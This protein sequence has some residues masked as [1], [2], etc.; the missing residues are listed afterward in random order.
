MDNLFSNGD[1]IIAL[2][3]NTLTVERNETVQRSFDWGEESFES[4]VV[5]RA[6]RVNLR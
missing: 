1:E 3:T 2:L 6:R 5:V 4:Q